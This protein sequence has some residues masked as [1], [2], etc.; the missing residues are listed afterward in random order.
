MTRNTLVRPRAD[1]DIDAQVAFL[2]ISAGSPVASR[3][4]LALEST[5]A[6]LLDMPGVGTLWRTREPRLIGI[7]RW[8]V[9][10]FRRHLVFYRPR[11]RG[12]EHSEGIEVIRI[13]HGARDLDRALR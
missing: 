6:M 5:F 3:F 13:L 2:L 7:R 11:G 12:P 4:L 9:R 8:S 10:G 1:Q